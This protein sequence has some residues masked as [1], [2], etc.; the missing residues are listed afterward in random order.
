MN[1]YQLLRKIIFSVLLIGMN[2]VFLHAELDTGGLQVIMPDNSKIKYFG[3]VNLSNPQQPAFS[4]P[5]V[6]IKFKC[7]TSALRIKMK[8]THNKYNLLVDG[9][10]SKDF[11]T[12]SGEQEFD[13]IQNSTDT[14]VHEFTIY[15]KSEN[16]GAAAILLGLA[17][18]QSSTLLDVPIRPRRIEFIGDSFTVGY[19]NTAPA[20]TGFD[21]W[22]TTD[23]YQTYGR[24]LADFFNA[25]FMINAWSGRGLVKNY[26]GKKP[27]PNAYPAMYLRA[28]QS[29]AAPVWNDWSFN[30]N[31]V[32]I[33]L[34]INDYS[35]P[36]A[37]LPTKEEYQAAYLKLIEGARKNYQSPKILCLGYGSMTFTAY[38]RDLVDTEKAAGKTDVAFGEFP[39]IGT[40]RGMHSHPNVTAHQNNYE[41]LKAPITSLMNW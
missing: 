24:L 22:E 13:L 41:A 14:A 28:V 3:R 10:F 38:V 33:F 26:G 4:W 16:T 19:G 32:V 25:E 27:D 18:D 39:D 20:T 15:K 31:L 35:T 2:L 11:V 30:P 40:N 9:V 1:L 17:V 7:A 29:S 34:G 37:Y 5:G 23:N 12:T 36:S 21:V 6:Y 8:D